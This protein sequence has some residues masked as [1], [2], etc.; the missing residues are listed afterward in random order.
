MKTL[1]QFINEAVS[2]AVRPD[3]AAICKKIKDAISVLPK[4]DVCFLLQST[5]SMNDV[6]K[7]C[8]DELD[9]LFNENGYDICTWDAMTGRISKLSSVNDLKVGGPHD[10]HQCIDAIE[11]LSKTKKYKCICV[12]GDS[13][14]TSN[15]VVEDAFK[16]LSEKLNKNLY[17]FFTD[18]SDKNT[19]NG[20]K[21]M[22][23]KTI[24]C[25]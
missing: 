24:N 7:G 23:N 5:G 18:D 10:V 12:L 1:T 6:K 16:Q 15:K 21:K 4:K 8:A 11:I 19:P 20:F 3:C 2:I 22:L 9:K 25:A 17:W 14:Y 13:L